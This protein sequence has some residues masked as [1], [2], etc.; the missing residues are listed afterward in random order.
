MLKSQCITKM[1]IGHQTYWV[2]FSFCTI[3]FCILGSFSFNVPNVSATTSELPTK[4]SSLILESSNDPNFTLSSETISD[5]KGTAHENVSWQTKAFQVA[6]ISTLLTNY[7]A[8]PFPPLNDSRFFISKDAGS[9]TVTITNFS[10]YVLYLNFSYYIGVNSVIVI[11]TEQSTSTSTPLPNF[12]SSNGENE[13]FK[14]N[15]NDEEESKKIP[16]AISAEQDTVL[17]TNYIVDVVTNKILLS[18][19]KQANQQQQQATPQTSTAKSVSQVEVDNESSTT[20]NLMHPPLGAN[21]TVSESPVENPGDSQAAINSTIL[22]RKSILSTNQSS[23]NFNKTDSMSEALAIKIGADNQ[24]DLTP[25]TIE[26]VE[27]LLNSTELPKENATLKENVTEVEVTTPDP[28]TEPDPQLVEPEPQTMTQDVARKKRSINSTE[29]VSVSIQPTNNHTEIENVSE[30]VNNALKETLSPGSEVKKSLTVDASTGTE[31]SNANEKSQTT[32]DAP[33]ESLPKH[34]DTIIKT[35]AAFIAAAAN[36]GQKKPTKTGLSISD[37]QMAVTPNPPADEQE[38]SNPVGSALIK[39]TNSTS[40]SSSSLTESAT[41]VKTENVISKIDSHHHDEHNDHKSNSNPASEHSLD[42]HHDENNKKTKTAE[43][44]ERGE[45]DGVGTKV[46]DGGGGNSSVEVR[47]HRGAGKKKMEYKTWKASFEKRN[48]PP[49]LFVTVNDNIIFDSWEGIWDKPQVL[50]RWTGS[51]DTATNDT[52]NQTYISIV[53]EEATKHDIKI[54]FEWEPVYEN[55]VVILSDII[56]STISMPPTPTCSEPKVESPTKKDDAKIVTQSEQNQPSAP[57]N[58]TIND[59]ID[60]IKDVKNDSSTPHDLE[61]HHLEDTERE[62]QVPKLIQKVGKDDMEAEP[63]AHEIMKNSTAKESHD[64]NLETILQKFAD[65]I[66]EALSQNSQRV[67]KENVS[68]SSPNLN[69][70]VETS[71]VAP[72]ASTSMEASTT[73]TSISTTIL[74]SSTSPT[75]L[76]TVTTIHSIPTLDTIASTSTT[77]DST[78]ASTPTST[79]MTPSTSP[80]S[81]MPPSTIASPTTTV[82][83]SPTTPSTIPETSFSTTLLASTQTTAPTTMASEAVEKE[84]SSTSTVAP[85]LSPSDESSSSILEDKSTWKRPLVIRHDR[86]TDSGIALLVLVLVGV[87]T[88][89]LLGFLIWRGMRVKRGRNAAR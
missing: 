72:T 69:V 63:V 75:T 66:N 39:E 89:F 86:K 37:A 29:N 1:E 65:K 55:A 81:T 31:T 70:S 36:S 5:I 64:V 45:N 10:G 40:S 74:A 76:P 56:L 6:N 35:A 47:E 82:T 13:R 67:V 84:S 18:T 53:W 48:R 73:S 21:G 42:S 4:Y 71:T 78:S 79:E 80:T 24:T 44:V 8:L 20:V 9:L 51:L 17:L 14:P 28:V 41:D 23:D 25:V 38:S 34:L 60:A 30:N 87:I 59:T 62:R 12:L 2:T 43:N 19:K 58:A 22:E 50:G 88:T 33:Q 32:S 57:T 54:T 27:S 26:K 77:S 49:G 16:I 83:T 61:E 52:W 7:Q 85:V 11:P 15:N 46:N 68:T 3:L